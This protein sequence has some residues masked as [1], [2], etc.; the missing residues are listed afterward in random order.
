MWGTEFPQILYSVDAAK[1]LEMQQNVVINLQ[2]MCAAIA[3][4]YYAGI[5][6]KTVRSYTLRD[7]I[8]RDNLYRQKK[9]YLF[10]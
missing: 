4:H 9:D 8:K 2:G 3:E 5:P 7:F 10:L 1:Q 6:E